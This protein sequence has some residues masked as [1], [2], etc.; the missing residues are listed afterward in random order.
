MRLTLADMMRYIAPYNDYASLRAP[1]T[2]QAAGTLCTPGAYS[3][4]HDCVPIPAKTSTATRSPQPRQST[5]G[6]RRTFPKTVPSCRS[7]FPKVALLA[8]HSAAR[9]PGTLRVRRFRCP[10]SLRPALVCGHRAGRRPYR[11]ELNIPTFFGYGNSDTVIRQAGAVRHAP[12]GWTSTRSSP[13]KATVGSTIP[14]V[15]RS[16]AICA[17]WL[18]AHNIAPGIL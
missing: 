11:A 13:R 2:L 1:L 12:P 8:I 6:C 15:W 7:A 3:W 10:D 18:A 14:S 4:L 16:S 17:D 5:I 9:A